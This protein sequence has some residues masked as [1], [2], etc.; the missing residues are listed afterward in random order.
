MNRLVFLGLALV[1]TGC[2]KGGGI[3]GGGDTR[4][5]H[6]VSFWVERLKSTNEDQVREAVKTLVD[7]GK[8]DKQVTEEVVDELKSSTDIEQKK[9]LCEILGKIGFNSDP[10]AVAPL[11]H[12]I[13]REKDVGLVNAAAAALV[14]I[15]KQEAAKAGVP[16]G[17]K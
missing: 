17:T 11:K 15:N 16:L 2:G 4:Q 10:I 14:K 13:M 3:F 1:L 5:N 12:I 9:R 6:P 8:L 7:N